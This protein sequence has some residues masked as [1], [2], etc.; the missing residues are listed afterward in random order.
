M[1][2]LKVS[3]SIQVD[4]DPRTVYDCFRDF[5]TWEAWSPW[6]VADPEADVTVSENSSEVGATYHWDSEIVGA[7]SMEHEDLAPPG[8][9]GKQGAIFSR[10]R[11]IRPWESESAVR[12]IILPNGTQQTHSTTVHWELDGRLPIFQFW[13][14]GFM[15]SAMAMDYD[16]GLRMAKELIESGKVDSKTT[17]H[18]VVNVPGRPS[19]WRVGQNHVSRDRSRNGTSDAGRERATRGG[20]QGHRWG[21]AVGVRQSESQDA[22]C[23]IHQWHDRG[24]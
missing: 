18:G 15:E 20:R 11:I 17:V 24:G 22:G 6:L 9:R 12:F 23:F 10:L 14:K 21:M 8:M 1:P 19:D 3:R 16:R 5:G 4:A 2:A 7:G 13:I